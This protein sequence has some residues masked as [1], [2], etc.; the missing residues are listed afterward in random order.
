MKFRYLLATLLA[1]IGILYST[2]DVQADGFGGPNT[3]DYV[4]ENKEFITNVQYDQL[5]SINSGI[6][7]E[8]HP[9]KLY[10][11]IF[12]DAAD[13]KEFVQ[14]TGADVHS[15]DASSNIIGNIGS[16]VGYLLYG[17]EKYIDMRLDNDD[18]DNESNYLILDLKDKKVF[19]SASEQADRYIT[20]L[21][22][23]KL[24]K[25]LANDFKSS[26]EDTQIKALFS[27]ANRLEP[28]LQDVAQSSKKLE[29]K[30]L[31]DIKRVRNR[32]LYALG[33]I[34]A[35]LLIY[36]IWK[37]MHNHPGSGSDLGNSDYDAGFDEG[38]YM[39]RNDP[40]M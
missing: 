30:D 1:F 26:D 34:V 6:Y 16:N 39:G 18:I 38:Y 32:I 27:L 13:I 25:G 20:D 37:Y 14:I 40:F 36:L 11:L 12:D 4:Y 24:R 8:P 15:N 29:S 2:Q 31:A 23:W 3:G 10:V 28:K 5:D 19:F 35:I 21:M 17:R 9:Q 22:F 7:T 33:T